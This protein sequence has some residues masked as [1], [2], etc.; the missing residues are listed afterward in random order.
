MM[1]SNKT[2]LLWLIDIE[3]SYIVCQTDLLDV[4]I[5]SGHNCS[6]EERKESQNDPGHISILSH[7]TVL[8]HQ[9]VT[10]ISEIFT[11]QRSMNTM[12]TLPTA[13]TFCLMSF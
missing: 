3:Q 5:R 2:V 1:I 6:F 8:Q 11:I 9:I 7:L 10:L 4:V 12:V 13:H